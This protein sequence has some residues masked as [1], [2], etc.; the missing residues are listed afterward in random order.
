MF[1]Y[2]FKKMWSFIFALH[3]HKESFVILPWDFPLLLVHFS[4]SF[5]CQLPGP[6]LVAWF[7][8]RLSISYDRVY[9]RLQWFPISLPFWSDLSC[10]ARSRSHLWNFNFLCLSTRFFSFSSYCSLTFLSLGAS[11]N[12]FL[13]YFCMGILFCSF[14]CFFEMLHWVCR[15]FTFGIFSIAYLLNPFFHF[16]AFDQLGALRTCPQHSLIDWDH[17][18]ILDSLTQCF[19][20]YAN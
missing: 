7:V 13:L 2:V 17:S 15:F 11:F 14:F 3:C 8:L 4:L 12:R 6:S 1:L 9:K 20:I 5:L 18:L 16:L 19:V 10:R